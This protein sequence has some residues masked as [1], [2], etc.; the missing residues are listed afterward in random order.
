MKTSG[1]EGANPDTYHPTMTQTPTKP[2]TQTRSEQ[3]TKR[4]WLWNVVL[5]NDEAHTY[6]YVIRICQEIFAHP[7]ERGLK[8]AQR[9]DKEGRAVL[10]T[11]HKEHAELKCEQVIS[12]G[13]DHQISGSKG[14]MSV[15]IEPAEFNGEEDAGGE[16]SGGSEGTGS[17]QAGQS[18]A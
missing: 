3:Q 8:I 11:T 14:A 13:K 15:I 1:L 4:P 9:V 12:F 5:L 18:P 7:A 6:E 10:M 17:N 16:E 2:E